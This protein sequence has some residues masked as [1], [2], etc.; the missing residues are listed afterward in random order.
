MAIEAKN[1]EN[2]SSAIGYR[3]GPSTVVMIVIGVIAIIFSAIVGIQLGKSN[4][5]LLDL[6]RNVTPE[7]LNENKTTDIFNHPMLSQFSGRIMGRVKAK[8]NSTITLTPISQVF[9]SD[10]TFSYKDVNNTEEV[11]LALDPF[12]ELVEPQESEGQPSGNR[13][14]TIDEINQGSILEG[15]VG[16][17]QNPAN[18]EIE[19]TAKTLS[20][21]N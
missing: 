10:G 13:P 21:R 1:V 8:S 17:K 16:F 19:F 14:I 5:K 18:Q 9:S 4:D 3:P 12:T 7:K 15:S 6:L 20:I 11:V 2:K